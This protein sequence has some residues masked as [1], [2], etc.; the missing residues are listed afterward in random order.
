MADRR[1]L[2]KKK[3]DT[4]ADLRLKVGWS[5]GQRPKFEEL[6]QGSCLLPPACARHSSGR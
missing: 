4:S 5:G 6:M 3:D 2:L 1:R